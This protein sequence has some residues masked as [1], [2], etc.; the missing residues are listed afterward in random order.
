MSVRRRV[1]R[2]QN[3]AGSGLA[4]Q[5]ESR[6]CRSIWRP[7]SR[8]APGQIYECLS[9]GEIFT[10]APEAWEPGVY[11]IVR[12]TLWPEGDTTRFVIDHDGIPPEWRDHIQTGYPTFY[13]RPLAAN[14]GG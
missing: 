7:R 13:Q 5:G 2:L 9:N 11:S 1:V 4:D 8:R 14:F 3:K 12:F 10:A 6:R